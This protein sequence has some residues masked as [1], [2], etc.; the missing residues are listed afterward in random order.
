[1]F[2]ANTKGAKINPKL[3][4][5]F[6]GTNLYKPP[7]YLLTK[8][9]YPRPSTVWTIGVIMYDMVLGHF[10]F[11]SDS[12]ILEH[13]SKE[14]VFVDGALSQEF[15]KLVKRCLSFYVA[16]RISIDKILLDPWFNESE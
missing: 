8:C 4:R 9:F 16:D 10:P 14:I 6:R 11:E 15:R 13:K 1:M 2:D 7:E 5:T 12:E 3:V